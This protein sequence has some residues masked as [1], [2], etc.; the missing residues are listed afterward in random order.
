MNIYV[1]M[2]NAG[3]VSRNYLTGWMVVEVVPGVPA[4]LEPGSAVSLAPFCSLAVLVQ[5]LHLVVGWG[6][7]MCG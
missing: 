4:G 2:I 6:I 3:I 7:R 5:V 1:N